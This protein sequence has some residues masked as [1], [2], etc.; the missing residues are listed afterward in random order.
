[1]AAWAAIPGRGQAAGTRRH[2]RPEG[3]GAEPAGAQTNESRNPGRRGGTLV[4]RANYA[5]GA[6]TLRDSPPVRPV[7]RANYAAGAATLRDSP[8]VR[9]VDRANYAAGAATLRDS[10]PARPG[11]RAIWLAVAAVR[12]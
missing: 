7:D 10:P 4:D 9:L 5:A 8:P 12:A 3:A 11:N 1:M 2:P 6:A